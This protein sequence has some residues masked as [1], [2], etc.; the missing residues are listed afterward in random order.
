MKKYTNKV[1]RV[2]LRLGALILTC[3]MLAGACL[4]PSRSLK[5]ENL[6]EDYILRAFQLLRGEEPDSSEF[7]RW[8]RDLS[9][10]KASIAGMLD[11]I[12]TS[13]E[14]A[15]MDPAVTLDALSRL[16]TD[17]PISSEKRD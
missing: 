6:L 8:Y 1:L 3:L 17:T 13:P 7:G 2:V 14:G 11:E 5:K 16:M 15:T 12:V 4:V 10:G 9:S